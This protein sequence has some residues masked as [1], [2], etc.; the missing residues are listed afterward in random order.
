[1]TGV[2][3]RDGG[4]FLDQVIP[5]HRHGRAEE[6]AEAVLFLASDKSSFITGSVLMADGGMHA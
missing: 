3:G 5:M 2:L 1:M 4:A 6:I